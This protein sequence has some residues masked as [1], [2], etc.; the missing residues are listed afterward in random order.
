MYPTSL[1]SA[2]EDRLTSI[3]RAA[4]KGY[5]RKLESFKAR[6]EPGCREPRP[7]ARFTDSWDPEVKLIRIFQT[8]S[9]KLFGKSLKECRADSRSS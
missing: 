6:I 4:E 3:Q 5:S 8:V 1:F 7:K 9:E 2:L